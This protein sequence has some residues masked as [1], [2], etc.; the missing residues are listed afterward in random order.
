[1]FG[2]QEGIVAAMAQPGASQD[3]AG[4]ETAFEEILEGL[5]KVVEQLE[6]G[7]LP[8]ER[9]LELFEQGVRLSR[10]GMTRLDQAE[11][12]IEKLLGDDGSTQ[13][14]SGANEETESQ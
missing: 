1:M 11:R 6:G 12:R 4:A 2:A 7:D 9:S 13:A 8:L 3:T 5:A 10:Q 14:W